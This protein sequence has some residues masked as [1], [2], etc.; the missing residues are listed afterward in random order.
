MSVAAV[1]TPAP[2]AGPYRGQIP[3]FIR[4]RL[5]LRSPRGFAYDSLVRLRTGRNVYLLLHPD[6]V[7]HVLVTNASNYVKTP[8]LTSAAGRRRAGAGLL[9]ASG[10]EHLRQRRLLQ[11]L[12]RRSVVSSLEAKINDTTER[13]LAG[14]AGKPVIDVGAEMTGLTK[15]IILSLLF[16]DDLGAR[17]LEELGTAIA[18]RRR[19]TELVY[20]GRLPFRTRLPT[21]T[22]RAHGRALAVIDSAIYRAVSARRGGTASDDDLVSA[23]VHA[24]YPDGSAMSDRQV[25]DE[26]LTLMSTGYE[27]LGDGL[28]WM[29]TLLGRH[30]EAEAEV[31]D[32]LVR[33]L[34][35]RAATAGDL[36]DLP[37]LEAALAETFRLYPPTWLF[38][39]V[40]GADDVLPVGGPVRAGSTL[41][42]CQYLM[43]RHPGHFSDPERFDPHRFDD[44][45]QPHR[46][47][48]VPFGDGLHRCLGEHLARLEAGLVAANVARRVRLELL[49]PG[50]PRPSAGV[51]LR[52]RSTVW[53]RPH[54]RRSA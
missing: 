6:D 13:M 28:T 14:W 40:P 42:I 9:T 7:R 48:Y 44:A 24:T 16:G 23:L 5:G 50:Q 25:R 20:Y 11:P 4:R 38:A 34:G 30:P 51:T 15:S 37:L 35:A 19:F 17:E 47:S 43:H 8:Q 3:V 52:P 12:F 29:W 18:D 26:I 53:A 41:Y 36:Q 39:R 32:E 54:A 21:A 45:R 2:P 33:V 27:T 1:S 10:A 49:D 31:G 46:F 22:V